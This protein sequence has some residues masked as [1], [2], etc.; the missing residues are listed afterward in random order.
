MFRNKKWILI[1]FGCCGAIDDEALGC[2]YFSP[3]FKRR[4]SQK[5]QP[6]LSTKGDVFALGVTIVEIMTGFTFWEGN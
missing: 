1:D 5:K 6:R 3:E 2:T 4:L